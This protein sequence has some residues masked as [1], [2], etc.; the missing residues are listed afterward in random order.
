MTSIINDEGTFSNVFSD[1]SIERDRRMD[2]QTELLI[3]VLWRTE[4]SYHISESFPVIFASFRD[5]QLERDR[6]TNLPTNRQTELVI[7][8]LWRS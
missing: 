2:G 6:P 5:F 1:F 4:K 7:E 8:V 3:E